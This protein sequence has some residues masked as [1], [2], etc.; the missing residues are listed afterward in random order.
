MSQLAGWNRKRLVS[1]IL[2]ELSA[3]FLTAGNG[4]ALELRLVRSHPLEIRD[5]YSREC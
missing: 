1:S 5:G 3:G 4:F 2:T